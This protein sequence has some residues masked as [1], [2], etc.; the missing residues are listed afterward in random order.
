MKGCAVVVVA[1]FM[2]VVMRFKGRKCLAD[3]FSSVLQLECCCTLSSIVKRVLL[4]PAN[5]MA[6][7]A[8]YN[9]KQTSSQNP[10]EAVVLVMCSMLARQGGEQFCYNLLWLWSF[11]CIYGGDDVSEHVCYV[12]RDCL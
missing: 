2:V 9:F 7:H 5:T 6:C 12:F 8:G 10:S 11:C 1:V 3:C 4:H